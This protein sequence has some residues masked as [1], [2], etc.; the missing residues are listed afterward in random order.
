MLTGITFIGAVALALLS[1]AF[2]GQAGIGNM[3]I[4]AVSFVA[5]LAAIDAVRAGRF[6]WVASLLVSAAVLNPVLPLALTPTPAVLLLSVS[7]ASWMAAL[8]RTMPSP[9]I[10]QALHPQ[11]PR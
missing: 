5:L 7:L 6:V 8:N 10:A 4:A 2:P 1:L 3:A 9:S 11:D